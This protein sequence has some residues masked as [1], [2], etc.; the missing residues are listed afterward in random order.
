MT[1]QT[2]EV[3]WLSLVAKAQ[4]AAPMLKKLTSREL[5]ADMLIRGM[6]LMGIQLPADRLI[7]VYEKV[8]GNEYHSKNMFELI[9]H[10]AFQEDVNSIL[11][12]S[13]Q[14]AL[15]EL[16]LEEVIAHCP[17]CKNLFAVN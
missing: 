16:P 1:P 17:Y 14:E 9:Q 13:A 12:Q 15:D 11:S 7:R 3:D 10:P 4:I 6:S 8:V 2:T 5:T